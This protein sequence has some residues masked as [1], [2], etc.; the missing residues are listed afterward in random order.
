MI[1]QE[2]TFAGAVK[3][4][5]TCT[6]IE[7]LVGY[8]SGVPIAPVP[9]AALGEAPMLMVWTPKALASSTTKLDALE[10]AGFQKT[11][12]RVVRAMAKAELKPRF[13]IRRLD[14]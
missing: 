5:L 6:P 9:E 7:M 8:T 4:Q 3:T 1:E 13:L 14:M 2:V 10:A 12:D 11:R